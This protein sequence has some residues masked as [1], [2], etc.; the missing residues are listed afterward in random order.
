[1]P[2]A[3][4]LPHAVE[5]SRYDSLRTDRSFSYNSQVLDALQFQAGEVNAELA[6]EK[7]R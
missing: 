5:L 3:G 7:S 6:R 2:P 4:M 1:M